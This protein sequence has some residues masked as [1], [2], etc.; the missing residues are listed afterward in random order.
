M[1]IDHWPV[2]VVA[3]AGAGLALFGWRRGLALRGAG[4]ALLLVAGGGLL[5]PWLAGW[6]LGGAG[7]GLMLLGLGLL[8]GG[9]WNAWLAVGLGG[10][11]CVGVGTLLLP[12]SGA[13]LAETAQG[14]ATLQFRA[15]AWLGLLACLPLV[16]FLS[17]QRLRRDELR[18]WLALGC[19]LAGVA[20]L[21]LA[22]AEPYFHQLA[23]AMTVLFVVD[24]SLSIP[25]E[26]GPDPAQPGAQIDLRARRL[27]RW[28]NDCV[29]MRGAGHERDQVG[30]IVFG[31]QPR[32][33][34]PPSDAPRF[35]LRELPPA[36][37]GQATNI[38]AALKLALA[39][40]PEGTGKRLVLVSDGNQ[41]LGDAEEQARLA[42]AL[43]VEIDVVPL[44]ADQRNQDEVLVERVDAPPL[45]EQ[46]ARVPIRVLVR[47][48]HPGVVVGRLILRQI[49]DKDASV[50]LTPDRGGSLGLEV[51]P[52]PGQ[53]RG[54]RIRRVLPG[55][56]AA[57]AGLEPGEDVLTVEGADIQ[58]PAGLEL[59][60]ARQKPGQA[61]RLG[62]RREPVR[63]VAVREAARLR[64]GLNPFSFDRPLT[65]EQRSYTYEAEF[66]P[67]Q[68]EDEQ[69]KVVQRGLPR[70]R[71]QNN[72]ASAHVLARGQGRLLL[73]ENEAGQHRELV[74][75]LV[76]AAGKRF[77]VVAEPVDL[78]DNYKG[79]DKL[80]VFLS[81]FDGVILADVPA[82]RISEEHQEVLRTNTHDQGCGLVMIGGPESFGAGGWQNTPVEKALPVD[83]DIRSLKVQGK[84]GLV[85]IMH[86]SE[87]AR[88]NYWQKRIAKLAVERLG[89]GDEVGVIDYGFACKWHVPMKEVGPNRADI[90]AAIDRMT[91]GDMPDFDPAL[92]MAH[93]ALTDKV[94]DFGAKHIIIISDG[95]PAQSNKGILTQIRADKI[96]VATV[97][98]ATHGAPEDQKMTDIA[99]PIPGTNRKRYYK[100]TDPRQLPAIY[101]KESR[102]VSQAFIHRRAFQPNLVLRSGPTA[103]LPDL[104]PLGGFVRTTR[105]ES[106]LVEVPILSPRFAD[107]DF[108]ILAH[109]NYGL[110]KSVA[111]TSDA[112]QPE[113]WSRRWL[114]GEAG[115]DG[116]FAGFWEQILG[117][118]LRPVE[119][120]Q[121][122]MTTE[123]RDGKIRILVEARGPDGK[124]DTNL[125]LRA[126]L[127]APG[128]REGSR[129]QEL[130]FTQKNAGQ[131]EAEVR[132]DEA[133]SYFITAQATRLRTVK[134]PGEKEPRQ[135]EEGVD[136]VRTG[137]TLPYSPEFVE[138]ESNTALLDRLREITGGRSYEDNAD[139][140]AEA[141]RS[142]AIFRAPAQRFRSALPFHYWLF[143][144]AAALLLADVA[145]RRLAFDARETGEILSRLWA[146]LRGFPVPPPTVASLGRVRARSPGVVPPVEYQAPSPAGAPASAPRAS[147]APTPPRKDPVADSPSAGSL[148]SLL[149]AKKR[150]WDQ[151]KPDGK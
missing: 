37:D 96:T 54:V 140:L 114:T 108:P 110:G 103:R 3:L 137:V 76:Q 47:S 143:L 115:R 33:E 138:L 95:D 121:L 8:L 72:R 59:L 97:G 146:R 77:R 50:V 51:D 132:A 150:V 98:V 17:W 128:G 122:Q 89:P 70:D 53:P 144:I 38:A 44:A 62:L 94:K 31:R 29:A 133:G 106:P 48:H 102:L 145:V 16:L 67:L 116:V 135:I 119:S 88:G 65:D 69:G 148:D 45:T 134:L 71:L 55:S 127:S 39:S 4:V 56:P 32:L 46:G 73:L 82:E 107:Q 139:L 5:P 21:A 74:E 36:D 6:L 34:L 111:F 131:Y 12:G 64:L 25:D 24:R 13:A 40:F 126:G 125:R 124:P 86:A 78:L 104:P 113:F 9:L 66:Q 57:R 27:L 112:G 92:E 2:L 35:N 147:G 79:R 60:L 142:G 49:T 129:R 83:C 19:R 52:I 20:L 42:K 75:R 22:L 7:L 93:K 80:A 63:I 91:P 109:W 136:S 100:V 85:L 41:N 84:G 130:R 26:P 10:T 68:V 120:G 28:I 11:L 43:G 117:W 23:R 15:P 101:V 151:K 81:N 141:A 99:S 90:L 18:P 58:G 61:V 14:L 30:L 118:V 87:M 1:L 105:K 123:Q 149:E